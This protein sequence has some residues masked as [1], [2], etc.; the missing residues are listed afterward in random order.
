[1]PAP[2]KKPSLG[3]PPT[4]K[5][6]LGLIRVALSPLHSAALCGQGGGPR[7]SRYTCALLYGVPGPADHKKNRSPLLHGVAGDTDPHDHPDLRLQGECLLS[8]PTL[9]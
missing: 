2:K 6:P 3:L 5:M 7:D 4:P 8:A 1:M 9:A